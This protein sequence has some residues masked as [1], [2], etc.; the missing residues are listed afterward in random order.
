MRFLGGRNQIP[1]LILALI[2]L[3][4]AYML[5]LYNQPGRSKKDE[6]MLKQLR[7]IDDRTLKNVSNIQ[8]ELELMKENESKRSSSIINTIEE[9]LL[10]QENEKLEIYKKEV[11]TLGHRVSTLEVS[12][13]SI[14]GELDWIKQQQKN[15]NDQSSGNYI[16]NN[17]KDSTTGDINPNDDVAL[18]ETISNYKQMMKSNSTQPTRILWQTWISKEVRFK[19]PVS[20]A[21]SCFASFG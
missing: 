21:H 19:I 5:G 15:Q 12:I 18:K 6:A 13:K 20:I 11:E 7:L 8:Y 10:G 9:K 14:H 17:Q 3:S 1:L 2:C 4:F 16:Q